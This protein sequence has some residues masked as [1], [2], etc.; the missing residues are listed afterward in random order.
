MLYQATGLPSQH[1]VF[2]TA[3]TS[4]RLS[5]ASTSDTSSSAHPPFFSQRG[6]WLN[7]CHWITHSHDRGLRLHHDHAW[8]EIL[9][10]LP[11]AVLPQMRGP[12][13]Q[14]LL[15]ADNMDKVSVGKRVLPH[16]AGCSEGKVWS[17]LVCLLIGK[18]LAFVVWGF[19]N[20]FWRVLFCECV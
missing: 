10:T 12:F 8:W 4:L 9:S 16:H 1:L 5:R 11:G 13:R 18:V 7:V 15:P 6:F 20:H 3:G 14:R 2:S 17:S 19:F